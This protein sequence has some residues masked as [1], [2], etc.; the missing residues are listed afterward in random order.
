VFRKTATD[1]TELLAARIQALRQRV[2]GLEAL[3]A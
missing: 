3:M 1:M 2:T